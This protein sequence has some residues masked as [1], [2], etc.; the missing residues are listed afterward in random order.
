MSAAGFV[1]QVRNSVAGRVVVLGL[2]K[3]LVF[4][5]WIVICGCGIGLK[6]AR[7]ATD[8]GRAATTAAVSGIIGA[9]ALDAV[10]DVCANALHI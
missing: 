7:S 1:T 2:A 6:A 10:F 4:G 8:V 3:S 5:G 9:V